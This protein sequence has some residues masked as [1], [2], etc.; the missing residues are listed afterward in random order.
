MLSRASRGAAW[1]LWASAGLAMCLVAERL[2]AQTMEELAKPKDGRSMRSTS[3]AVDAQGNYAAD[4]SDNSRV[5][6]RSPVTH[7][8]YQ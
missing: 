6:P 7:F 3:T 4:N 2:A 5:Y 8:K 1:T